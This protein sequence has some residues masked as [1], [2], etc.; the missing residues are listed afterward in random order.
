MKMSNNSAGTAGEE[1]EGRV[2]EESITQEP[3]AV[4]APRQTPQPEWHVFA[5]SASEQEIKERFAADS[6][7]II[8][9]YKL[10]NYCCLGLVEPE[11]GIDP[12]ESDRILTSLRSAND[13]REKDVLLFLLSRGGSVEP[14]YQISKL[15]KVF[16]KS[17]FVVAVPRFAKSAATLIALGADEVHLGLLGELGPIDPQI[18]DLPALGVSQALKTIASIASSY[19]KSADMFAK[20]LR[21]ALTVEQ[22]GYCDRVSDSA[23]QYAERLL[24]TKEFLRPRAKEIARELVYEYKHHGFVIDLEEARKHLGSEWIKTDTQE[25]RAGEELYT[26]FRWINRLLG[27][28]NKRLLLVGNVGASDSLLILENS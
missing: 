18:G 1:A 15:C 7:A 28:R 6:V 3:P 5:K 25:L 21:Q 20:Y 16:A 22:I 13:A 12:Y 19:P 11:D 27:I 8:S 23:A 9:R 17:K 10:E 2:A 24:S 4:E 26:H 14:A